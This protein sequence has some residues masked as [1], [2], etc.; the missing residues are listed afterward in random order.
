[1][2]QRRRVISQSDEGAK[3][4]CRSGKSRGEVAASDGIYFFARPGLDGSLQPDKHA[5]ACNHASVKRK[6]WRGLQG[7]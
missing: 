1:M 5:N 4:M 2:P 6:L 3:S 7:I